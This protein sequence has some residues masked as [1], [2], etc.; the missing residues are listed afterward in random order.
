MAAVPVFLAILVTL[1][2][3]CD[4]WKVDIIK[5]I[6]AQG[7]EVGLVFIPGEEME[8]YQYK[9]IAEYIQNDSEL[10]VWV[11][12]PR[13]WTPETFTTQELSMA[14]DDAVEELE[15][16]GMM[17]DNFVAVA[18]GRAGGLLLPYY[19]KTSLK[20]KALIMMGACLP[21]NMKLRDFPMPVLTLA[22]E[23]DGITRITRVAEEYHKLKEDLKLDFLALYRTPV[24]LLEKANHRQ[25]ASGGTQYFISKDEDLKADLLETEVHSK[26]AQH[27]D[28]FLTA[29][30]GSSGDG[31]DTA[32]AELEDAFFNSNKKFQPFL[33]I[34]ELD[35]KGNTSQWTILA[36]EHFAEEYADKIQIEN[37]VIDSKVS[38][39]NSQ[40]SIDT[41]GGRVIVKTTTLLDY[42]LSSNESPQ[43]MNMKLKSKDAIWDAIAK[44][45]NQTHTN[46]PAV[47][48][49]GEPQTCKSLNEYALEVALKHSSQEARDRY[50]SSGRQI[51]FE[52]DNI[53]QFGFLWSATALKTWEE[54]DGLHVRAIARVTAAS[55][56]H[57]CKVI[58][59]YRAMEWINIDSLRT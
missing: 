26:A 40:P 53:V 30:F 45:K 12:L 42:E 31:E 39:F 52:D 46:S 17:S 15:D 6:R 47:S 5:P 51:I 35:R 23:L 14:V 21:R 3:G 18:H 28:S 22:A 58:T 4:A 55:G 41:I 16:A 2:T 27:V 13:M 54:S 36:Q 24:I 9:E 19:A 43:E 1:L 32:Q 34:K 20:L 29:N 59:P 44:I 11:A 25:F 33:D 57:F 50:Q 56:L 48:L 38:F 49:K 7:N 10:R 8:Y 37:E